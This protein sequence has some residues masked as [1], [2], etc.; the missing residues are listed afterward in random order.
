VSALQEY[1]ARVKLTPPP[2]GCKLVDL[3]H[4]NA[5]ILRSRTGA[6]L[7]GGIHFSS[8]ASASKR[9]ASPNPRK[10]ASSGHSSTDSASKPKK[11]G[12]ARSKRSPSTSPEQSAP[13][14]VQNDIRARLSPAAQ[15]FVAESNEFTATSVVRRL[16]SPVLNRSRYDSSFSTLRSPSADATMQRS[17]AVN[18]MEDLTTSRISG[19]SLT[20]PHHAGAEAAHTHSARGTSP[21]LHVHRPLTAAPAT[22]GRS[23]TGTGAVS[24]TSSVLQE[25]L[26]EAQ[27][28]FAAM[29]ESHQ[30]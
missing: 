1:C 25:R 15:R 29:R 22:G 7:D 28:A 3:L 19:R 18:S 12:A 8:A 14:P 21:L 26:R 11:S 16:P 4:Y 6:T 13:A 30:Y 2:D 9:A 20:R 27:K 23:A 10:N 24:S 17:F 5:E